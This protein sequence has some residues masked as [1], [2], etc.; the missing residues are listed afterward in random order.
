[1]S[2]MWL[3]WTMSNLSRM[4]SMSLSSSFSTTCQNISTS[5]CHWYQTFVCSLLCLWW[6][7]IWYRLR[8]CKT[9]DDFIPTKFANQFLDD[10]RRW[11]K[12][13]K[14]Y[15]RICNGFSFEGICGLLNLGN[16]CFMNS[17]LQAFVHAPGKRISFDRRI[18]ELNLFSSSWLFSLGKTSL[19]I[20]RQ[21][22]FSE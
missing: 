20:G 8:T 6:C 10:D 2:G 22:S 21:Q 5:T 9:K 14:K 12:Y 3:R 13:S 17:V 7:S 11:L 4:F 19:R 15:K 18:I 16:T 1:M